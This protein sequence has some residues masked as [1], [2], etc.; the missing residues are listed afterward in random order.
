MNA[1]TGEQHARHAIHPFCRTLI[2]V[3]HPRQSEN[4]R[5]Q[6][7]PC[8]GFANDQQKQAPALQRTDVVADEQ[9]EYAAEVDNRFWIGEVSEKAFQKT[10]AFFGNSTTG[11][12]CT[13]CLW[14]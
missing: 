11:A 10:S 6:R 9:R 1:E 3:A 12:S 4:R 5:H 13:G 8:K 7:K 14:R 2:L